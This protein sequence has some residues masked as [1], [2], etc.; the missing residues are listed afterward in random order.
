MVE[1]LE[2]NSGNWFEK[3]QKEKIIEKIATEVPAN[4][5]SCLGRI[6]ISTHVARR[7]SCGRSFGR[8]VRFP[9]PPPKEFYR[10]KSIAIWAVGFFVVSDRYHHLSYALYHL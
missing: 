8:W 2:F 10:K 9:P 1:K 4:T 7:Y 3:A 6:A 5:R